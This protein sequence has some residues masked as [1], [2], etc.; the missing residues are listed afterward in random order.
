MDAT[1]SDV[2]FT[3]RGRRRSRSTRARPRSTSPTP[4]ATRCR[5]STASF[6]TRCTARPGLCA[7]CSVP[8]TATTISAWRW[9]TRSPASGRRPPGRVRVNGIGERAGNASL[10]EIVML[11]R[12]ARGRL[13]AAHR[14]RHPRD[15]PHRRHGLAPDRLSRPAEQGGRRPQRVRARVRDPPGRGPEGANDLRDHGCDDVGLEA[16]SIVLGKHSGRHALQQALAELG[17][18]VTGQA[19]KRAFKRFKEIADK[20]KQVTAMDLEALLTD[21]LRERGARRLHA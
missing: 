6:L 15:R 7:T 1:R 4:S 5:R 18:D 10:E 8:C 20:K 14:H 16:N 21:E 2:E 12:H 11:L 3:G 13:R 19:L 17:F 9:P